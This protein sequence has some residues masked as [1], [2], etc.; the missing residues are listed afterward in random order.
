MA[1]PDQPA[2]GWPKIDSYHHTESQIKWF[3]ERGCKWTHVDAGPGDLILW[4][5]RLIHYGA[6]PTSDSPRMATCEF[7]FGLSLADDDSRTGILTR[8]S[9]FSIDVCYKPASLIESPQ[10]LEEKKKAFEEGR[11]TVSHCSPAV[12]YSPSR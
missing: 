12:R 8:A 3:E 9:V 2:G 11:N 7:F 1:L 4:D 6:R 10:K 5:S